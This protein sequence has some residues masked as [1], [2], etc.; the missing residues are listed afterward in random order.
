MPTI[1]T[2]TNE[3]TIDSINRQ[4]AE[5]NR[6]GLLGADVAERVRQAVKKNQTCFFYRGVSTGGSQATRPM[7]ALQIDG[8]GKLWFMSASDSHKNAE[9]ARNR[10]CGSSSKAP[11][12]P[13]SSPCR[14]GAAILRDKG[15]VTELW[16]RSCGL[17]SP[18][19]GRP[20]DRRRRR[21]A[22]KHG[23]MVA[24]AKIAIGA[25]NGVTL[26]DSIEGELRF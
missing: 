20:S 11:S 26:D 19:A 16:A 15:K 10:W 1:G 8:H 9:I 14:G 13:A 2:S 3:P 23:D 4:Q 5:N 18:K 21:R 17:S 7:G 12:I 22:D 25:T 6:A 24:G